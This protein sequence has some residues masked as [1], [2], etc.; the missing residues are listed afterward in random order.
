MQKENMDYRGAL[1]VGLMITPS[2]DPFVLEFNTRFGDPETQV[3]LPRLQSD[4][5]DLLEATAAARL[6]SLPSL[7]WDSKVAVYVVGAAAG[8]P[9][10]VRTGDEI[11]LKDFPKENFLFYSGV[12]N[13]GGKLVTAGGRVLGVGKLDKDFNSSRQSVYSALSK[14]QWSGIH[15]RTD[16]GKF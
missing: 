12:K 13:D 15:F 4:L 5:V 8:Y 16:I 2:G 11:H 10:K 1:F 14:I 7:K 6:S 9:E 3:I